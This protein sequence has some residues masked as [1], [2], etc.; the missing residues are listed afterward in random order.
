[1][2]HSTVKLRPFEVTVVPSDEGHEGPEDEV[3]VAEVP[4]VVDVL[5]GATQL[6]FW[7]KVRRLPAPQNSPALPAHTM[8]QS[9]DAVTFAV[10]SMVLPQ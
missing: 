7:N 9:V 8:L 6:V 10:E 3:L 4:A 2:P 1:M 5:T